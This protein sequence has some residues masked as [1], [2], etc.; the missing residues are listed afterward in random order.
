[1]VAAL[2][3]DKE[4]TFVRHPL[5][6]FRAAVISV[7]AANRLAN[8]ARGNC[9]MFNVREPLLGGLCAM[10]VCAG[11]Q[12]RLDEGN[13]RRFTGQNHHREQRER[14]YGNG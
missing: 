11:G 6:R 9:R 13:G 10:T 1:M 4:P 3:P 7:M 2:D 12:D 8:V 14:C 5:L